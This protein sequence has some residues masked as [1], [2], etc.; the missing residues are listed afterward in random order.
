MRQFSRG[1]DT[2]IS[3]SRRQTKTKLCEPNTRADE[4]MEDRS[5]DDGGMNGGEEG[6]MYNL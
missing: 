2:V 6:E 3:H 5:D 4:L 1:V